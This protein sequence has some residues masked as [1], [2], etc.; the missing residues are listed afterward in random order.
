MRLDENKKRKKRLLKEKYTEENIK[1]I[2]KI[3][4]E[5]DEMLFVPEYV[6]VVIEKNSQYIKIIRE[7][8]FING[9]KYVR[10]LC[11]AG[12]ARNNT[13]ALIREDFEEELKIN[14]ENG[15]NNQIK[16]TDNKFNAYFALSSTATWQIDD[17]SHPELIPNVLLIDDC[18]MKMTK[19][20]DWVENCEY[21]DIDDELRKLKN[22]SKISTQ[23]KELNFN[24]FDGSGAIDISAAKKWAEILELD[25]IP[26]VFI[27]RNIY[28]K[29]CLFVVDFKKFAKEVAK[30]DKIKDLYGI[31]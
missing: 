4:N 26:S 24:F 10:L 21:E 9:H 17:K 27:L 11:G 20:V 23:N 18:E 29:G 1:E 31:E 28:I 6:L 30:K 16:I 5:I 7:G 2:K 12:M 3:S 14:L 13:V 22:K 19:K 15:W 8:L 25:Y